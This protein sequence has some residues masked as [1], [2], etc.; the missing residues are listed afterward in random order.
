[1]I[2][3]I[4]ASNPSDLIRDFFSYNDDNENKVLE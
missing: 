3:Q 2:D 1:M 4:I